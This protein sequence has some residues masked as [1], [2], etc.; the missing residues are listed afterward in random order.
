MRSDM[1]ARIQMYSRTCIDACVHYTCSPARYDLASI[2]LADLCWFIISARFPIRII[3]LS[4][5]CV[6]TPEIFQWGAGPTVSQVQR[7]AKWYP[8]LCA[9]HS[10]Q[11]WTICPRMCGG[12]LIAYMQ[13]CISMFQSSVPRLVFYVLNGLGQF[14]DNLY[15]CMCVLL[16]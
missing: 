6:F 14:V 4:D 10:T 12:T 15:C 3:P 8:A 16:V 11:V 2:D 9:H 5:M 1:H 13:L 7:A